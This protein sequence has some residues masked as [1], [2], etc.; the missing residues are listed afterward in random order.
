MSPHETRPD[1]ILKL[2]RNPKIHVSTLER[3][4]E[5]PA[6]ASDED[7]RPGTDWRGILRGP[8]QLACRLDF[9]EATHAGP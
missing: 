4:P 3:K 5:V 7:L 2:D 9:P 8:S 6:S 1:S